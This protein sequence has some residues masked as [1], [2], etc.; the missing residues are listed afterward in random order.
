M[1]FPAFRFCA[2]ILDAAQ[3][4]T[5][6]K[7]PA[8]DFRHAI[9]ENDGFQ[10]FAA[11]ERA[12]SNA[13]KALG[14]YNIYQPEIPGKHPFANHL[15]PLGH[16]DCRFSLFELAHLQNASNNFKLHIAFA[17][18]SLDPL[19]QFPR[20]AQNARDGDRESP[21]PVKKCRFAQLP[22][23]IIYLSCMQH[24]VFNILISCITFLI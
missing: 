7:R 8:F 6:A 18:L 24:T 12:F 9:R 11:P 14:K 1:S 5:I 22:Y 15:H 19:F 3:F 21:P 20:P 4:A 2:R 17:S 10:V 16:N 13:G 23:S